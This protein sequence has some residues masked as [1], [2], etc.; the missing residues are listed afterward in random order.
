M[1]SEDLYSQEPVI[2]NAVETPT[3]ETAPVVIEPQ[4]VDGDPV[5]KTAKPVSG[6]SAGAT[7]ET[8]DKAEPLFDINTKYIKSLYDKKDS[9]DIDFVKNT[10]TA[11]NTL[12]VI[13]GKA[14]PLSEL[15]TT[16]LNSKNRKAILEQAIAL[17]D[18]PELDPEVKWSLIENHNKT[19][20]LN[21]LIT[22][23]EKKFN[24]GLMTA[25]TMLDEKVKNTNKPYSTIFG[26]DGQILSK[27]DYKAKIYKIYA[28]RKAQYLKDNPRE[29]TFDAWGQPTQWIRTDM[30]NYNYGSLVPDEKTGKLKMMDLR[31]KLEGTTEGWDMHESMSAVSDSRAIQK[32]IDGYDDI[33]KAIQ[34]QYSK[35]TNM[36]GI[37]KLSADIQGKF[38]GNK[39]GEEQARPIEVSFN[40]GNAKE[41]YKDDKGQTKNRYKAEVRELAN[42]MNLV[43]KDPGELI[44]SFGGV[45]GEIPDLDDATNKKVKMI[46][47]MMKDDMSIKHRSGSSSIPA[48]AIKFQAITGGDKKYHAY[49][50]RLNSNY[51]QSS[52]FSG[53][54]STP[55][56]IRDSDGKINQDLINDGITIY[57]PA[58]VSAKATNFGRTNSKASKVSYAEG[59]LQWNNEVMLDYPS[60]GRIHIVKDDHTGTIT[61]GGFKVQ[62]NPNSGKYDTTF[63]KE[64]NTIPIDQATDLDEIIEKNISSIKE[65][66]FFNSYMQKELLRLKGVKDINQLKK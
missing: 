61:I 12:P 34:T 58:K 3:V 51:I 62:L 27:A 26:D 48:G 19:I 25:A 40:M 55:G 49:T 57:V 30:P 10:F 6:K 1:I 42:V 4:V 54:E 16:S 46:F 44:Y 63:V 22:S 45:S 7:M 50:I 66:F 59:L 43:D 64:L 20:M 60:A 52:K 47:N 38:A 8:D 36:Q 56:P 31:P 24:S 33:V 41:S 11:L 39:G 29:A 53:S 13:N 17:Q 18:N 21:G 32:R 9:Y 5:P 2:E 35:A 15:A 65:R 23:A 28:D 14:I 37:S